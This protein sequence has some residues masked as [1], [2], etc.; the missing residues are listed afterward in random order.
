[1]TEG[2]LT[3][4]PNAALDQEDLP[5]ESEAADSMAAIL[6]WHY[7]LG[8]LSFEKIK[9]L[10]K[11]CDVPRHLAK[12]KPPVCLGCLFGAMTRV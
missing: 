8:H 10:A 11:Q 12:I 6:R 1:M 9:L 3:F 4:N 5:H 2:A 7:R